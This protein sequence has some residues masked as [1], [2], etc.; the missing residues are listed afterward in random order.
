[1]RNRHIP[2]GFVALLFFLAAT[3]RADIVL[4]SGSSAGQASN[5]PSNSW[6][7]TPATSTAAL[8]GSFD[9]SNIF[10][11]SNNLAVRFT[12]NGMNGQLTSIGTNLFLVDNQ[13]SSSG[14]ITGGDLL[15]NLYADNSGVAQGLFKTALQPLS[16]PGGGGIGSNTYANNTVTITS[17][18]LNLVNGTTYTLILA[19]ISATTDSSL[20]S[21]SVYWNYSD[22]AQASPQAFTFID[23]GVANITSGGATITSAPLAFDISA[24]PEPETWILMSLTQFGAITFLWWRKRSQRCGGNTNAHVIGASS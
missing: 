24:V 22:V 10:Q 4:T 18:N 12:T 8:L 13:S 20:V 3:S 9:S 6:V 21:D 17:G 1:M 23:S 5:G 11:L 15:W 16:H 19:G 2:N 7:K 14:S